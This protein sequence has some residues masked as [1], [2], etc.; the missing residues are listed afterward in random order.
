MTFVVSLF[1]LVV[2]AL[3][4]WHFKASRH[5]VVSFCSGLR[6]FCD[7]IRLGGDLDKV[8]DPPSGTHDLA[9]ICGLCVG[10]IFTA[11]AVI[12]SIV[13]SYRYLC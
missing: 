5:W 10:L 7:V 1:W 4:L 9:A 2:T 11:A 6:I 13:L 12:I 8:Q 3:A